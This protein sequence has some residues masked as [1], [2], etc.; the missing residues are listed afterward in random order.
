MAAVAAKGQL[1]A[2]SA[3][4]LA[5]A[6]PFT[7]GARRACCKRR[8]GSREALAGPAQLGALPAERIAAR[9]RGRRRCA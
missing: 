3:A 2:P 1:L 5:A 9:P 4:F 6:E 8:K 7:L